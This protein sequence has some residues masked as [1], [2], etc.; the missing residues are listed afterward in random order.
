LPPQD[1][2]GTYSY[3]VLAT[4]RDPQTGALR[5]I[6]DLIRTIDKFS[7]GYA[8]CIRTGNLMDQAGDTNLDQSVTSQ[9]PN[10]G[11]SPLDNYS[12]PAPGT[13]SRFTGSQSA[14][15]DPLGYFTPPFSL[16]SLPL[17]VPGP[18]VVR[19]FVPGQPITSDNL[20]QNATV[21]FLDITFDRNMNPATF[22]ADG[23][24]ILRI[25]G[26]TGLITGAF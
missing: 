22:R 25:M 9:N 17:I 18:H 13:T 10:Y 26:P 23:S 8:G 24:D 2:T 4:V 21:S 1:R 12:V 19:T 14:P 6:R 16:D 7:T 5:S 20:V 3:E 11:Q 15:F